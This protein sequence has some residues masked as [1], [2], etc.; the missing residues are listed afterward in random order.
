MH[1]I[2]P[3]ATTGMD[4]Q[5][6]GGDDDCSWMSDLNLANLQ[7]P[8]EGTNGVGLTTTVAGPSTVNPD[9]LLKFTMHLD[10]SVLY[11]GVGGRA[12]CPERFILPAT[13]TVDSL[14]RQFFD[15]KNAELVMMLSTPEWSNEVPVITP[16]IV[17]A[18]LVFEHE[19]P[20]LLNNNSVS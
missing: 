8:C 7:R 4:Q 17:C 2:Q 18:R 11:E 14:K 9:R 6:S 15:R 5:T 13:D 19:G 1:G 3:S 10:G 12:T 16:Q 20:F